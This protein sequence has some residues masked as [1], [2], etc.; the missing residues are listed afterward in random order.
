MSCADIYDES[1]KPIHV[2]RAIPRQSWNSEVYKGF[3]MR[4]YKE[5]D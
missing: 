5:I 3:F 2:L 4:V 1:K